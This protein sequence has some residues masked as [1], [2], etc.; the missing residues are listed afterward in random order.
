[1][2]RAFIA[3]LGLIPLAGPAFAQGDEAAG[4][5]AADRLMAPTPP[6]RA[7]TEMW[8]QEGLNIELK[9]ADWAPGAYKFVVE[10][11]GATVTCR[12]KLPF[13]SCDAHAAC[14]GEGV[15]IGESGCALPPETHGFYSVMLDKIPDAVKLTIERGDGAVFTYAAPVT[16]Q[17]SYPNGEG[18]DERQCCSA[19][20]AADVTWQ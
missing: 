3:L 13:D 6:P 2:K 18:C 15:G 20:L 14:D 8:C 16:A 4:A 1:M 12:A 7:C 9:A 5:P 11:G 19:H 17:C 10:T